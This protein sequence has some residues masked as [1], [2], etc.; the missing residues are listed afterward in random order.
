MS[1]I[2]KEKLQAFFHD[3]P[4]KPFILMTGEDHEER[5]DELADKYRV[6]RMKVSAPDHI[7]SAMERSFLPAGASRNKGLQ[8][9][10]LEDPCI[11]HP[12]SGK[13]LTEAQMLKGLPKDTFKSAVN[14]AMA[15]AWEHSVDDD[16]KRFLYLWRNLLPLIQKLSQ[17]QDAVATQ[18][19]PYAPADTRIPDHSIFE[20]LRIASACAGSTYENKMMLNNCSLFLFTIGPVQS[21]IAQARKTQDLYWG[22]YI[23][24]YLC[25]KAIERV[26]DEYGP[27]SIIF[28]DIN[29]QPLADHWLKKAHEIDAVDTKAGL[30]ELPTMPN[31]F[32]ALLP[33]KDSDKLAAFGN[34]LENTVK[35]VFRGIAEV[36]AATMPGIRH[37]SFWRQIDQFI[38]IYWAAVPWPNDDAGKKAWE[39]MLT[40][41]RSYFDDG[42]Y[43]EMRTILEFAAAKGEY[44]PNVG[45][46]YGMMH[47]LA[48]KA[49]ASRKNSRE[50]GQYSE[51][52]R[53][54]SLCGERNV[55][56]YRR[57]ERECPMELS[58]ISR[59][60]LY[61]GDAVII[62]YEDI[63]NVPIKYL[64]P[65]EGLC[66]VCFTKR[67]T[68]KYFGKEYGDEY[69]KREF[70]STTAIAVSNIWDEGT[71]VAY[72][73]SL[74][75][76]ISYD[77]DDENL[78]KSP[79]DLNEKD[80]ALVRSFQEHAQISKY[81]ISK[82]Y[83]VLMLDGDRMGEWLAGHRG[84]LYQVI[85]HP[86]VWKNLPDEFKQ[87]LEGQ[88]RHM[89][90]A[91]HSAI[92]QSL[93]TYALEFVRYIVEKKHHGKLV[94]AGGDDVMAMVSIDQLLDTMLELRGAFSGHIDESYKVDFTKDVS[95]FVNAGGKLIMT[96]GPTASAS[97]G[98][99]IA[100]YKTPLKTVLDTAWRMVKMA[101]DKGGRNAFAITVL[102]HSGQGSETVYQWHIDGQ[103]GDGTVGCLKRLVE[104]IK[105]DP[106]TKTSMFSDK[107]IYTMRQE[108][109]GLLNDIQDAPMVSTE[110][111]RLV[112]RQ[113]QLPSKTK[114][115]KEKKKRCIQELS[116]M[117]YQQVYLN[118][119]ELKNFFS[120]MDVAAFLARGEMK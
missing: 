36:T 29:G 84:P 40:E 46:M 104:A 69:F 35:S 68:E 22:S 87:Q 101:K 112:E 20:H 80:L 1:D 63:K 3:P 93:K 74:K 118:G 24:S 31:R 117:L 94:Y 99:C 109:S 9:R 83:A 75:R 79:T 110:L 73:D 90:P 48:E 57:N 62:G 95:G 14:A 21:F 60:K 19:W 18:L 33:I 30:L 78:F 55:M 4:D 39:I 32:M 100:Y 76:R 52:G 106:I 115:E 102:R 41:C 16:K 120:F 111:N 2:F 119:G 56:V 47:S 97:M 5:A 42:Q 114:E 70:P 54:C 108:F 12:L 26:A 89:T 51:T 7:A 96:M 85:Y 38:Q 6:T 34:D 13:E 8:V 44:Q 10:Y 65:G 53:K 88:R 50:F 59:N 105:V 103:D 86:E 98:V 71:G 23:L 66:A 92:S 107:F 82:Y 91:I 25:W 45:N 77:F 11:K 27:D 61:H 72:L 67:T 58:E 116:G 49:L 17:D 15:E 28:P 64:Q 81:R 113:C 43:G 37:E